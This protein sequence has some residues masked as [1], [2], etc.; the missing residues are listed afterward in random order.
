MTRPRILELPPEVATAMRQKRQGRS[1]YRNKPTVYGGVRY[2][3]KAEAER[4]MHLDAAIAN[5]F[6]SWWIGQPTFR[7]GCPE[8]VYRP[9]FLVA[10]PGFNGQGTGIRAEDVKG[11]ETA[12][13]K[14]DKKLWA[15]YGP[16]PLWIV[17]NGKV[18]EVIEPGEVK[19]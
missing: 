15:A 13:F 3:S 12:K 6:A 10:F 7:L 19:L 11:V 16:V 18:V 14:R 17:R 8:N 5:G 4:A 9:D 1:K 2:A